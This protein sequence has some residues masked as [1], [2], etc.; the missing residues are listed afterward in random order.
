M[1]RYP[2]PVTETLID[3]TPVDT[4][5]PPPTDTPTL[6]P[7][8]TLE[9]TTEV[10]AEATPIAEITADATLAPT[11]VTPTAEVTAEATPAP[12]EVTPT[13]EITDLPP[14]TPT[15]FPTEP[16]L[17]LLFSDTF[18]SGALYLWTLGAGWSLTPSEG[19]SALTV[20]GSDAPL[21]FVHATL[22]DAAAEARVRF[23]AGAVRLSLQASAV[24][25][26]SLVLDAGGAVTLYRGETALASGTVSAT[27]PGGW[28]MLRLSVIAGVLRAGVDGVEVLTAYDDAPL[29]PGTLTLESIG[30]NALTV[31]DVSV[32]LA[33]DGAT[34]P[35]ATAAPTLAAEP[36]WTQIAAETFT[37]PTTGMWSWG[38]GWSLF[39]EYDLDAPSLLLRDSPAP[40]TFS[41][42]DLA[43]VSV[44]AEVWLLNGSARMQLRR[45]EIG[46]YTLEMTADGS[47]SLYRND[48]LLTSAPAPL[49][50]NDHWQILQLSAVGGSLRARVNGVEVLTFVDAEPLPAGSVA[51][52]GA[53]N[54][55]SLLLVD[56]LFVWSAA[57]SPVAAQAQAFSLAASADCR[58]SIDTTD[59]AASTRLAFVCYLGTDSE[60]FVVNPEDTASMR[61][62][63]NNSAA[64]DTE[65]SLSP[66][67]EWVAFVSNRSEG[68]GIYLAPADGTGAPVL[69]APGGLQPR[70]SPNGQDIA[71]TTG[72][73]VGII[74]NP[75]TSPQTRQIAGGLNNAQALVWHVNSGSLAFTATVGAGRSD[76]FTVSVSGGSPTALPN[77]SGG[78][79]IPNGWSP[80]DNTLFAAHVAIFPQQIE[81]HDLD[82]AVVL[83][84]NPSPNPVTLTT[85]TQAH[86]WANNG[87][88]LVS[89]GGVNSALLTSGGVLERSFASAG[90]GV[91]YLSP[92]SGNGRIV[93]AGSALSI[94]PNA[95]NPSPIRAL[96]QNSGSR[97]SWE[98]GAV[99]CTLPGGSGQ[100]AARS[101]GA[102]SAFAP[103][104]QV[105]TPTPTVTPLFVTNT[106]QF[107]ATPIPPLSQVPI[108]FGTPVYSA[109]TLDECSQTYAQ[110]DPNRVKCWSQ[111]SVRN[112][113][114]ELGGPL[115]YGQL[116]SALVQ[117]EYLS[118]DPTADAFRWATEAVAR[119]FYQECGN[120]GCTD[121]ELNE[122]LEYY[123]AALTDRLTDAYRGV[124]EIDARAQD[125]EPYWIGLRD[126]LNENVGRILDNPDDLWRGGIQSDKPYGFATANGVSTDQDTVND[127]ITRCGA[128]YVTRR[129]STVAVDPVT[130]EETYSEDG[131][132]FYGTTLNT[133]PN[134]RFTD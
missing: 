64:A 21:T 47:L 92:D 126:N 120:D 124:E 80:A 81:I 112:L 51:L 108:P 73:T 1:S 86:E 129:S 12:T 100:L 25:R 49:N 20:S 44:Q 42:T 37:Y 31:D 75:T 107:T 66:D 71:Y 105:V 85:Y 68:S 72:S 32:W 61:N 88:L 63:S 113:A 36:T 102:S 60:I 110:S 91:P 103:V 111:V 95:A 13:A 89:Q 11:E 38:D 94:F 29:P 10:T 22:S 43:E 77:L 45:T 3:P 132:I 56:D 134:C 24:A 96:A 104:C 93:L 70:W 41:Q 48:T 82:R 121:A 127:F 90:A 125:N 6:E 128:A 27:Q 14:A 5:P 133:E 50:P 76:I 62:V 65:P 58:P 46:A 119:R 57:G 74:D 131:S 39:E 101:A 79:M 33:G 2:P 59:T 53:A 114:N 4:T 35:T 52:S 28:R 15:P 99:L 30:G 115:T 106:P 9:S 7:T 69:L 54:G 83:P 97:V 55:Q 34:A 26:Y 8:L 17:T 19:G 78:V 118:L 98:T 122:F 123:Q 117:S 116:M 109:T 40:L 67:G 18:D 84:P 23:E 130:G 87:R 16:P